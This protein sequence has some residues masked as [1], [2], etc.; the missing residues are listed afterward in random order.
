M[1]SSTDL[2]GKY[3][4]LKPVDETDSEFIIKLRNDDF[5]SRYLPKI[6]DDLNGQKNW[7]RKQRARE[8]EYYF[9]ICDRPE[10]RRIGTL[11]IYDIR[12]SEAETGRAASLGT[13]LQNTE[14]VLLLYDFAFHLLNLNRTRIA[15]IP[16]NENVIAMNRR[17]GYVRYPS[18]DKEGMICYIL[19]RTAYFQNTERIRRF[20]QTER[21]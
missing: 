20:Y 3:V 10:D 11:S 2:I 1:V 4:T 5:I 9:V 7:I 21:E 14:A 12:G 19:E 18:G 17:L 15:I 6:P 16:G 8:G 13:A